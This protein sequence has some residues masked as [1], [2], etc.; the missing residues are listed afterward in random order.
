MLKNRLESGIYVLQN[1]VQP[2]RKTSV[3]SANIFPVKFAFG[4]WRRLVTFCFVSN[5]I[6]HK[7]LFFLIYNW[8]ESLL[9]FFATFRSVWWLTAGN[10]G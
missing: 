10:C 9:T 2:I 6:F 4:F 7:P 3:F 1:I 8:E 5:I